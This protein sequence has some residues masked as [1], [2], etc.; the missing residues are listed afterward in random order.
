MFAKHERLIVI[1]DDILTSP[2]T[3][4]VLMQNYVS[5]NDVEQMQF[6][7]YAL[8]WEQIRELDTDPLCTIAGHTVS[9]PQ[10]SK[11]TDK[12]SYSE[13]QLGKARLEEKLGHTVRHF[14]YPFGGFN[15]AGPREYAFA[16]EIGFASA[17]TTCSDVLWPCTSSYALPRQML[18]EGDRLEMLPSAK[19]AYKGVRKVLSGVKR[20]LTY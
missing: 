11:L 20:K 1:E 2:Y 13:I 6:G 18:F 9:Y 12:D 15:E 4:T 17:C 8:T 19:R 10:L 5:E 16:R 3:L 7:E 14:A